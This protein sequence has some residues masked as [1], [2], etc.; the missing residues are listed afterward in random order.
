MG[1]FLN[2]ILALNKTKQQ[3]LILQEKIL[4]NCPTKN[5][6]FEL[7]ENTTAT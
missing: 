6:S 2:N 4:K 7:F 1:I 3:D 5:G